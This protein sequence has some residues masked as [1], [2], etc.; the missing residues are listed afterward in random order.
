MIAG[1][2]GFMVLSDIELRINSICG[3]GSIYSNTSPALLNSNIYYSYANFDYCR[4]RM[5]STA[6]TSSGAYASAPSWDASC[7]LT[8]AVAGSELACSTSGVTPT[9]TMNPGLQAGSAAPNARN[10]LT[11]WPALSR[12]VAG[13]RGVN[14]IGGTYANSAMNQRLLNYL[15]GDRSQESSSGLRVR[16]SILGDMVNASPVALGPPAGNSANLK[17]DLLNGNNLSMLASTYKNFE[18]QYASRSNIVY[19]GANDGFM[20]AFRAGAPSG[21]TSAQQAI[22]PNDGAELFAYMPS[23]AWRTML[24]NF[25]QQQGGIFQLDYSNPSYIHNFYV[26][27]TPGSGDVN[28]NNNWRTMIAFGMGAGAALDGSYNA[29]FAVNSDSSTV[30]GGLTILDVTDPSTFS[31][32]DTSLVFQEWG[33]DNPPQCMVL[34]PGD[35]ALPPANCQSF[36]GAISGTPQFVLLHNGDSGLVFGN[37]LYSGNGGA[38]LFIYDITANALYYVAAPAMPVAGA[39]NGIVE[40]AP[41]DV[42]GDGVVDYVYGGDLQGNIWRFDLTSS[43]PGDWGQP[44]NL[45]TTP[46]NTPITTSP[47]VSMVKSSQGGAVSNRVMVQFATGRVW[48]ITAPTGPTY[49]T[50]NFNLYGVWDW[51]MQNWDQMSKTLVASL[52]ALP[53][54]A[55]LVSQSVTGTD[56]VAGAYYRIITAKP[57]CWI[58]TAGVPGCNSYD[59]YGWQLSLPASNEQVVSNPT[60]IGGNFVVNTVIPA[61]SDGYTM[62]INMVTGQAPTTFFAATG[63]IANIAGANLQGVGTPL[64]VVSRGVGSMY[65][66]NS[67]QQPT[68]TPIGYS[69]SQLT[70]KRLTWVILR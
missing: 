21:S 12:P 25:N 68:V 26:D 51:N 44:F 41:L 16:E 3:S 42:D 34:Q 30:Q 29:E 70:L 37:G 54:G 24:Y 7:N 55:T 52:A 27:A 49:A 5:T 58:D 36:M 17:K 56:Y 64:F 10:I 11:Y 39:K 23:A 8:G 69:P 50:G 2:T 35:G 13:L 62:V 9:I 32:A 4:G 40:V 45:F 31:E 6:I 48:P 38:G 60:S 66:K 59:N 43:M 18:T 63:D 20:H 19:V 1:D 47:V 53:D 33:V 22:L 65:M 67:G 14:L 61:T 57:I 15:R 46:G 28:V